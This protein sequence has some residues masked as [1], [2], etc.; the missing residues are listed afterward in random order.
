M[1]TVM[2]VLIILALGGCSTAFL[3]RWI[4]NKWIVILSGA[5][6]GALLWILGVYIMLLLTAP[7]ELGPPVFSSILYT[8]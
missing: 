8:L 1:N 3:Q 7:N 4:S 6:V 5:V 2:P